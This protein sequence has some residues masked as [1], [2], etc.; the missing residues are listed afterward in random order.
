MDQPTLRELI[1][2]IQCHPLP[3]RDTRHRYLFNEDELVTI[4]LL[5]YV[6]RGLDYKEYLKQVKRDTPW[7]FIPPPWTSWLSLA[8]KMHCCDLYRVRQLAADVYAIHREY[9][10]RFAEEDPYD[11]DDG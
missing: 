7:I 6:R 3:Y 9:D 4:N 8:T 11:Y 1:Y 5:E 10:A 2:T